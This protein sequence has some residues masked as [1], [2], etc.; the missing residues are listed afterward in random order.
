MI[1]KLIEKW[2]CK[3]EWEEFYRR[4]LYWFDW[5]KRP[6]KT[7]ITLICKKCGKIKKIYV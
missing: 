1:K 4:E 2:T 7:K 3:H 5:E 6:Y